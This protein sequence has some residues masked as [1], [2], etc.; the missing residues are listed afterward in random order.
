MARDSEVCT[1]VNL[2]DDELLGFGFDKS[3]FTQAS[4]RI[5]YTHM[6]RS[7]VLSSAITE[8]NRT[9]ALV[10]TQNMIASRKNCHLSTCEN[11]TWHLTFVKKIYVLLN[12]SHTE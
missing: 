7:S 8:C 6:H 1:E 4:S 5:S 9:R 11:N 10:L 2:R 12:M 3:A